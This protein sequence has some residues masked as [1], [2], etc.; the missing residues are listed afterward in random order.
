M[1]GSLNARN[2][3]LGL[4]HDELL[5]GNEAL[6]QS[7][8]AD[9]KRHFTKGLELLTNEQHGTYVRSQLHARLA[10]VAGM[11]GDLPAAREHGLAAVDG[12]SRLAGSE[13]EQAIALDNLAIVEAN[14]GDLDGA[15][16]RLEQ[17]LALKRAAFPPGDRQIDFTLRMIAKIDQARGS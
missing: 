7:H 16:A 12:F 17:A 14:L 15:R 8:R 13:G 4:A 3:A 1:V 2:L 5:H 9:A 11:D 6:D 10:L